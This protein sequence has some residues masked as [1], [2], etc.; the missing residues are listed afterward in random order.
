MIEI[1]LYAR[2]DPSV[3]L[4][5]PNGVNEY[6]CTFD[7]F[8]PARQVPDIINSAD[9]QRILIRSLTNLLTDVREGV[10]SARYIVE[11]FET[12][13]SW[14]LVA[15]GF[16]YKIKKALRLDFVDFS[17]LAARRFFC[18]AELQLNRRLAPELYLSVEA[19]TG[20]V[21]Q[22][23][24]S[25]SGETIDYLVKMQAFDQAAL[26]SGRVADG[27]LSAAEVDALARQIACF[28]IATD[29]APL[30]STWANSQTVTQTADEN[31]SAL[32]KLA[33]GKKAADMVR[34]LVNWQHDRHAAL[35]QVFDERK[36]RGFVRECHGDLHAGNVMTLN[37]RV[38]AFDC[39]EFNDAL[40]WIDVISDIAFI[41]MDL[42]CL[43][44][45]AMAAR[46]LDGYLSETADYAGLAV[47]RYYRVER[48]LVRARV[49]L[50]QA[51]QD[52]A[53]PELSSVAARG[54]GAGRADA[55]LA[56][57]LQ[58]LDFSL[59]AIARPVPAIMIT[60]GLSGSGKS[61][62]SQCLLELTRAVRLR[63][64]IERK[65]L[66][67][68]VNHDRNIAPVEHGLY[69]TATSEATYTHLLA[70]AR[71]VVA[72]GYPVIVDAAFLKM[73]HRIAFRLL[74]AELGVPFFLFDLQAPVDTLRRRLTA[75]Q[76]LQHH[77]SDADLAVLEYQIATGEPLAGEEAEGMILI[78][79]DARFDPV[80]VALSC[81]T[82]LKALE[83]A[84]PTV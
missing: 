26:W 15:G 39:I 69:A 48:A 60:H 51:A 65:R 19:I 12:H 79:G 21:E 53:A 55:A 59:C 67:G 38:F 73:R 47:L 56:L 78:D 42:E 83:I 49:N 45:P 75:R 27:S 25:G 17:T 34:E 81:A 16:A 18:D 52:R 72:A 41:N 33:P 24:I 35:G 76:H 3:V 5:C 6:R 71:Q 50:L 44:L 4:K 14:V 37:D 10:G 74:A 57:A 30:H 32:S 11:C 68:I 2:I 9:Q 84:R 29:R 63:S 61:T 23:Q 64:D 36:E 70:L 77:A 58:Y 62:F 40:R 20:S 54:G 66:H 1:L 43:G 28:H 31:L 7:R 22:P 46:L 8:Y 82:V 80:D 13:L